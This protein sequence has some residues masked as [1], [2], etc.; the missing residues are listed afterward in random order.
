VTSATPEREH[1]QSP[2]A[3][4]VA[5]RPRTTTWGSA[6]YV[7]AT[8]SSGVFLVSVA[9]ALSRSGIRGS[10]LLFWL[11]ILIVV[12]P[13]CARLASDAA[14]R[15]ERIALV[16]IVGVSLYLVKVLLDPFAFAFADEYLHAYNADEIRRTGGLFAPNP[17]LFAS[18]GF[19]GL[20][21]AAAALGS[22]AGIGTFGAGLALIGTARLMLVVA[23]FLFLETI[24]NSSRIAGLGV[25]VY[26][27]TPN[28][29][30]FD[31]QFSYESLALPLGV[32]LLLALV[33][34]ERAADPRVRAAWLIVLVVGM[35]ALVVTHHITSYVFAGLFVLLPVLRLALG[36]G[37]P[38]RGA[39]WLAAWAVL[40]CLGWLVF[41]ATDTVSYLSPVFGNG[42]SAI[43][44]TLSGESA[45]RH[46]FSSTSYHAPLWERIVG[47]GSV[48]LT[49]CALPLGLSRIWRLQRSNPYAVIAAAAAVAYVGIIVL[50]LVPAAWEIANRS[51]E[52]LGLGLAL[53][54]AVTAGRLWHAGAGSW[55][56]RA[57]VLACF[58]VIMVG[59]LIAGW[60]PPLRVSQP[61]RIE[62]KGHAIDP[63]GVVAASW[64][65]TLLG[66]KQR[67]AASS[68]D[69]R[70]QLAL[71]DQVALTGTN[72]DI[73][74]MLQATRL[75]PFVLR[76][77]RLS[78]VQYALVDR[79]RISL[80]AMRGVFF[81]PKDPPP[82]ALFPLA[83]GD[84]FERGGAD[85]LFDSGDIV[86]YDVRRLIGDS[87]AR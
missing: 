66:P 22:I 85:R 82:A 32:V 38:S 80:D 58:A 63:Q 25:V 75:E 11:G 37:A 54:L 20:E 27:I 10:Q 6:P 42:L 3:A 2:A 13:A 17:I 71:G 8:A 43:G 5:N 51:S 36:S 44:K 67:I 56:V 41:V 84:K 86:V 68:A 52:F 16:V 62:A 59:N 24:A 4:G 64:S 79:Q 73:N 74:D 77:L 34:W 35:G 1:V 39:W 26:S 60:P 87:A 83:V 55:E 28:F 12:L 49:A 15:R 9:D 78:R 48:L 61:Y 57:A 14:S 69:A 31:A 50:R 76:R 7:L 72:P 40:A 47:I 23:L 53:V 81:R 65:R 70:L 21:T 19:P 18:P 45:T 30:F 33:R 29:L 46:L